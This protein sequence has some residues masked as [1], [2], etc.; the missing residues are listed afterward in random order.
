MTGVH[1]RELDVMYL[2]IDESLMNVAGS[3]RSYAHG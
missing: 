2:D 3:E 1:R